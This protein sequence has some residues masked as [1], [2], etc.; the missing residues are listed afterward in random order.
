MAHPRAVA[1]L[2]VFVVGCGA[3]TAKPDG[4]GATGGAAS[5]G[6]GT[7]GTS[8]PTCAG[9]PAAGATGGIGGDGLPAC[10]VTARP[11]DPLNV[12][13]AA[14][15]QTS[16]AAGTS[17]DEDNCNQLYQTRT[18]TDAGTTISDLCDFQACSP[19][20]FVPDGDGGLTLDGGAMQGA[21]G[22]TLVDGD[23]QLVVYRSNLANVGAT[24]RAIALYAGA[25][26]VEWAS[27]GAGSAASG[28]GQVL[29]LN[30]TMS[31]TGDPAVW[32]VVTVN[33]G[34]LAATSYGYTASGTELDLYERGAD[35][36]L[37]NLYIYQRTC[38]R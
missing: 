13:A 7:G 16:S 32:K 27:A 23:Y 12:D 30:T 31:A 19:E 33:C 37:Q 4:G 24:K 36:V 18:K 28:G 34:S 21:A 25:T 3:S 14:D 10:A 9:G 35:G 2:L 11:A 17:N 6:T 20:T 8:G 5:G 29:R 15:A 1:L 26:Y 38:S 22:G